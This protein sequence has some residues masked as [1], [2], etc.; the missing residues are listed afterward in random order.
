MRWTWRIYEVW[1]FFGEHSGKGV[2]NIARELDA[3]VVGDKVSAN[4]PMVNCAA[5]FNTDQ[6]MVGHVDDETVFME[7]WVGVRV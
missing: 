5:A 2:I 1:V 6:S 7:Y 3:L 4:F